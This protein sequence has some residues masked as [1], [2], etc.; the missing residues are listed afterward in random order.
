MDKS[1]LSQCRGWGFTDVQ[2]ELWLG[3]E[4]LSTDQ[5]KHELIHCSVEICGRCYLSCL[6]YRRECWNCGWL[7]L[8]LCL[9]ELSPE[10]RSP[11]FN[12]FCC[13]L[14]LSLPVKPLLLL[15]RDHQGKPSHAA[16]TCCETQLWKVIFPLTASPNLQPHCLTGPKQGAVE[17]EEN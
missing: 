2:Y 17:L 12:P 7:Q 3:S 13:Q 1:D 16:L 11:L 9:A 6:A 8:V 4:F 14:A 5:T 15:V 10:L